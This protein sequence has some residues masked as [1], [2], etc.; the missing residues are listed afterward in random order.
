MSAEKGKKYN[1]PGKSFAEMQAR[2]SSVGRPEPEDMQNV[3]MDSF[4]DPPQNEGPSGYF[5]PPGSPL[6]TATVAED[7]ATAAPELS[8]SYRRLVFTV[9]VV[10]QAVTNFDSG[11]VGA[12]IGEKG[13]M[14]QDF[15]SSGALDGI[16]A[17]IV[18]LGNSIGGASCGYLFRHYSVKAVL[19][20]SLMVH[21]VFS[22][23]FAASPLALRHFSSNF[24]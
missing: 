15:Q 3:A 5:S 2:V 13:G 11:A 22:V 9:F 17:S 14:S 19:S 16:L 1:T 21:T 6:R 23:A 18:Y 7:A 24:A 12:V 20:H 10:T 4:A 8:A